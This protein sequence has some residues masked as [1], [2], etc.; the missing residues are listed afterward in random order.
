MLHACTYGL[1]SHSEIGPCRNAQMTDSSRRCRVDGQY[2]PIQC[3][4]NR[5]ACWC[6]CMCVHV[7]M[8][9]CMHACAY[10]CV[11][12][13]SMAPLCRCVFPNG[14]VITGSTV[15]DGLP[16]CRQYYGESCRTSTEHSKS[17]HQHTVFSCMHLMKLDPQLGS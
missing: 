10:S 1:N 2:R 9:T 5:T 12:H 11:C 16:D 15:R 4:E 13:L 6:V 3:Y 17:V 8:H 7:Y 14:T